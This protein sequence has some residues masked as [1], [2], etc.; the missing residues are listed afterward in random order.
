MVTGDTF[1]R[2]MEHQMRCKNCDREWTT[3]L[4]TNSSYLKY[5]PG[6]SSGG[7]WELSIEEEDYAIS[8]EETLGRFSALLFLRSLYYFMRGCLLV[9]GTIFG[10]IIV[11][12]GALLH[13]L[14]DLIFEG[15]R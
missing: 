8:G 9:A 10:I 6:C 12:I 7:F 11:L 2:I 1:W 15:G 5:C 4:D 14:N 13:W 3:N